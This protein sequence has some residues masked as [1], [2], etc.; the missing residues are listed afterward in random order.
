MKEPLKKAALAVLVYS[1]L[2]A[3]KAGAVLKEHRKRREQKRAEDRLRRR[4]QSVWDA[5]C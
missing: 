5:L 1:A 2:A 4:V 3:R